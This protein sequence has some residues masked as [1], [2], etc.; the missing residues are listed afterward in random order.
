MS[1]I[2]DYEHSDQT[3][4]DY[5]TYKNEGSRENARERW[6]R[7]QDDLEIDYDGDY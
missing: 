7:E 3:E 2:S 5:Q 4:D 6:E 1:Y